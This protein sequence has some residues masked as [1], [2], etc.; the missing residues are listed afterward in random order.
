MK[1]NISVNLFGTLYNI[2]EDAYQLL[3]QYEDS[4][5]RYFAR[6]GDDEEVAQDIEMRVAEHFE[7]LRTQGVHAITI[8]HVQ[9]II[10]CIGN[11]DEMGDSEETAETPNEETPKEEAKTTAKTETASAQQEQPEQEPRK[12]YRD[13]YDCMLGGVLS[14]I[15]HYFGFSANGLRLLVVLLCLFVASIPWVLVCYLIA[16]I[17]VPKAVTPEDRL[18]MMGKPV[19]LMNI[20][21]GVINNVSEKVKQ[22]EPHGC[23]YY[24]FIGFVFCI[25][26]IVILALFSILAT[27]SL[28]WMMTMND[29]FPGSDFDM[30]I[31]L[32]PSPFLPIFSFSTWGIGI[33]SILFVVLALVY[34]F[35]RDG[36]S[37]QKQSN[38]VVKTLLILLLVAIGVGIGFKSCG[39]TITR[40]YVIH[41]SHPSAALPDSISE[42]EPIDDADADT[43]AVS[44]NIF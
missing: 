21:E 5:R 26:S 30:S 16:C 32:D 38:T 6:I 39:N 35:R 29:L 23:L 42:P 9:D 20:G 4:V 25:A 24:I 43:M 8:E 33:A 34:I 19:N 31:D 41:H 18:R 27:I 44:D 10:R 1:K 15:A 36:N 17:V 7:A 11:P 12:L 28:P 22:A 13:P 40:Q 3:Q 37:T 14:G 2:D